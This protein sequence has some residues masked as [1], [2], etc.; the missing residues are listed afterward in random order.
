MNIL[1]QYLKTN[2]VSQQDFAARV[3]VTQSTVSKLCRGTSRP[4]LDVAILIDKATGGKVPPSS[5]A[6]DQV[7]S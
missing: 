2:R 3:G 5:W 6:N 4:S 7:A 1:N